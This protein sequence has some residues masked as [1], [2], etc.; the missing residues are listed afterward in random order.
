MGLGKVHIFK[1]DFLCY[2]GSRRKPVAFTNTFI[3]LFYSCGIYFVLLGLTPVFL[4]PPISNITEFFSGQNLLLLCPCVSNHL[5][6][7]RIRISE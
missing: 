6:N 4:S 1:Q 3:F 5:I 7:Y 2:S